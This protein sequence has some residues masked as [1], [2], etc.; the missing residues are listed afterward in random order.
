MSLW[1][2]LLV[3]A[4]AVCISVGSVAAA[5]SSQDDVAQADQS[6]Q[7]ALS[8]LNAGDVQ[9]ARSDYAAFRARWQ[10]IEDGVHEASPEHYTDI[11]S[12][13]RAVRTALQQEP[14]DT[15]TARAALQKLHA[16]DAEFAQL[17][18]Q[19]ETQADTGA[20]TASTP[21][22]R[23]ETLVDQLA[24]ARAALA[25]HDTAAAQAALKTFQSGWPEVEG[26]VKAK[27]PA[28]YTAT[29]NDMES[30]EA[31]LAAKPP[32]ESDADAVLAGMHERLAP[33][34]ESSTNYGI[35]DASII[36]LREGLEALLVIGALTAFLVKSGNADKQRWIWAG[37][38]IGVL[39]SVG[40]ALVLQQ[41]FQR[42]GAGFGSEMVEGVVG[43]V[44]AAMLFYVSYWLH[45]K[46]RLG[47]WQRYI[48]AKSTT[49]LARGSVLS[50]ALI[51][52]LAVFREGAETAVFYLGIAPGIAPTDL[53]I[54]L[55][56]GIAALA[57]IGVVIL[58][59]GL[60]L[61][62]RPFFLASSA[63]IYYL[64]FKFVGT[65]LHALQVAGVLH[66][67]PAP[68]PSSDLL[69]VYPTW[70]SVLPQL[71]LLV[72]AAGVVW[73]SVRQARGPQ[74][75]AGRA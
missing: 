74:L 62:L 59:L 10:E 71:M 55:G 29:E 65:G 27:A 66:A 25:R 24:T 19:P 11:E 63:L 31:L 70:E 57:A 67:T 43:L 51:A 69:G 75:A 56:L 68:L 26:A 48:Q 49:A 18:A 4:L 23:L 72:V 12:A 6:I 61:R 50:L 30:A 52:L 3:A 53:V 40:L 73:W 9:T 37:A 17:G 35:F 64:G 34:A 16:E 39:L 28:A 60:R 21:Q 8:A 20:A 1:R 22:Q 7:H 5:S 33:L 45:S 46:A 13:M 38:G 42:A 32:R 47:G 44:A 41:V 36:M 15:A 2:L 14:V 58:M 54:G